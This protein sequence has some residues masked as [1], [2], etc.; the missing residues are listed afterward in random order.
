MAVNTRLDGDVVILSNF[1]RLMNDPKHV[2]AARDIRTLIDEGRRLFV[3]DLSNLRDIGPAGLGLLTTLTRLARQHGGEAVLSGL[4]SQAEVFVEE[5]RMDSYWDA[6][7][8]T[9]AAAEFLRRG[10][11]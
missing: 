10:P 3:L 9:E 4:T 5:M 2:D 8:T 7:P 6:F 1:A 11:R